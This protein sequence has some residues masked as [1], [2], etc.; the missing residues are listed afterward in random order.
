MSAGTVIKQL[1]LSERCGD[2]ELGR[3][4]K[5]FPRV[6]SLIVRLHSQIT[7][8][9]L[10]EA[11]R[12]PRIRCLGLSEVERDLC[13]LRR[14]THSRHLLE[15]TLDMLDREPVPFPMLDWGGI[16]SLRRLTVYS[17]TPFEVVKDLPLLE[18]LESDHCS[19]NPTCLHYLVSLT[20]LRLHLQEDLQ[21]GMEEREEENAVFL[22]TLASLQKLE[23]LQLVAGPTKLSLMCVSKLTN[24]TCLQIMPREAREPICP[25]LSLTKLCHLSKLQ[26]FSCD[27]LSDHFCVTVQ[28]AGQQ[29]GDALYLA[30]WSPLRFSLNYHDPVSK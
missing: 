6:S 28:L 27:F 12:L 19:V 7:G 13:S 24:L 16:T 30:P 14:V 1:I 26:A 5:L 10:A 18:H 17:D 21:L 4:L 3:L 15:L 22:R 9:G 20:S 8:E 2:V 29:D 25:L 11:L 23:S